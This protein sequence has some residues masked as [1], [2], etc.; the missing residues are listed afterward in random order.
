MLGFM[1]NAGRHGIRRGGSTPLR[2]CAQ[3][4]FKHE[5]LAMSAKEF[6][7]DGKSVTTVDLSNP[8]NYQGRL[9]RI[10]GS[11]SDHWNNDL[12]NHIAS[13]LWLKHSDKETRDPQCSGTVA[14]LI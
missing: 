4:A 13:T 2:R 3:W 9:K 5:D 10:G 1:P 14:A 7:A 12:V 8:D 11:Q 6:A